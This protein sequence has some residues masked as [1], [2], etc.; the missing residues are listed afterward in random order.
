MIDLGAVLVNGLWIL[1][2]AVVLAVLSQAYA[3]G[4]HGTGFRAAMQRQHVQ[5]GLAIGLVLFC[6][7]MAATGRVWWDRL[8]WGALTVGWAVR[9]WALGRRR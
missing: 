9:T 2:L 7:G 1:G 8:L 4:T 6:A 5:Q 3:F